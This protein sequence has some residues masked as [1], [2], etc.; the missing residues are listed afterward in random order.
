MKR[1]DEMGGTFALRFD[2]SLN[3]IFRIISKVG[4]FIQPNMGFMQL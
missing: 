4:C 1:F 2:E 3:T